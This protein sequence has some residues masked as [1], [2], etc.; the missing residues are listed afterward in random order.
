MAHP[1]T[2]KR[3]AKRLEELVRT[4]QAAGLS[5]IEVYYPEHT[6]AQTDRYRRLAKRR[7][8][9]VTGGSDYHGV[10][11]PAI[12]LGAGFGS[13]RVPDECWR[14]LVSNVSEGVSR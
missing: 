2:M 10:S 4:L 12:R 6:A 7:G 8:L 3:G 5:G 13:L 14:A 9:A 11:S 1:V